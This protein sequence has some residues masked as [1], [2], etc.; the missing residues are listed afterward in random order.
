MAS[1]DD[2]DDDD[3]DVS[4]RCDVGAA[5]VFRGWTPSVTSSA[6][7]ELSDATGRR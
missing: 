3:D 7:A 6:A 5:G 4:G 1:A 2:N